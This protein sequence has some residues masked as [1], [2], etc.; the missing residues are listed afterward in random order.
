LL[1][2]DAVVLRPGRIG[3][4]VLLAALLLAATASGEK[5][6]KHAPVALTSHLTPRILTAEGATLRYPSFQ[7]RPFE[8]VYSADG[9]ALLA[10][11]GS[12]PSRPPAHLSAG[13]KWLSWN[14]T[15]ARGSGADWH[16]NCVPDCA[17]GTYYRYPANMVAY[18]PRHLGGYLLYTR[19]TVTY[20]GARPPYP[21]YRKGFITFKLVYTP[22]SQAFGWTWD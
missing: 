10:G 3:G 20:T 2:H 13:L 11:R 4:V 22:K 17:T 16:D 21:A 8:I 15:E 14:S 19:L 12:G 18:R 1:C 7:R 5:N 9:S 6:E